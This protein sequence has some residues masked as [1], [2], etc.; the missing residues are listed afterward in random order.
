MDHNIVENAKVCI[1]PLYI[2]D[3]NYLVNTLPNHIINKIK[4]MFIPISV[5]KDKIK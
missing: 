1:L 2:L 3:L 5:I 4:A